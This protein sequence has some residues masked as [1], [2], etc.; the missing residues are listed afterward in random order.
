M[1]DDIL[2]KIDAAVGCH[3][4]GGLLADDSP[5]GDFCSAE[6]QAEWH[7]T[8][9]VPLVGYREPWYRPGEFPGV[10]TEAFRSAPQQVEVSAGSGYARVSTSWGAEQS[11]YAFN[12]WPV[13]DW[14]RTRVHVDVDVDV[15]DGS[16]AVALTFRVDDQAFELEG[17]QTRG[18]SIGY[19]WVD[20]V[21]EFIG[22]DPVVTPAYERHRLGSWHVAEDVVP[23]DDVVPTAQERA[24][25][26]RRSRNTGPAVRRRAP[27]RIDSPRSR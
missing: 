10:G 7:A 14:S 3:A 23:I 13:I 18:W 15:A 8:H 16:D 9:V 24:L 4:C 17:V 25:E 22:V 19:Q 21:A 1:S 12:P 27:R 6:C 26:A 2:A 11:G 5:S 20:E